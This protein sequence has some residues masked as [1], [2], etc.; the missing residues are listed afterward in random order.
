MLRLF[1]S[2]I[3]SLALLTGSLS[4]AHA[5]T[6]MPGQ[7]PGEE[8]LFL[9]FLSSAPFLQGIGARAAFYDRAL[10]STCE[11]DYAVELQRFNIIRPVVIV[12]E[13]PLMAEEG[14]PQPAGGL[15]SVKYVVTRCDEAKTYNAMARVM[16][17]GGLRIAILVPGDTM[18]SRIAIGR[19]ARSIIQV[20]NI[21]GCDTIAVEDTKLGAPDGVSVSDPDAANETWT[22]KGCDQRVQV[23]WRPI[24]GEDNQPQLNVEDRRVLN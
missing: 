5:E 18:V 11:Q 16:D 23:V 13:G 15:W 14:L 21:E 3:V 4:A 17:A 10:G 9:K 8:S 20:A 19:V 24:M 6:I 1:K 2:T 7:Q 22:V 12:P